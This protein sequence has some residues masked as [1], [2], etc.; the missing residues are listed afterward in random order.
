MAVHNQRFSSFL[1][2][3]DQTSSNSRISSGF[4]GTRGSQGLDFAQFF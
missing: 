4:A 3:K 1:S 2:T